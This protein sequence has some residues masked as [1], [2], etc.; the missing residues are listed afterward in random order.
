MTPCAS[1]TRPLAHVLWRKRRLENGHRARALGS[2]ELH[3][4]SSHGSGGHHH[5]ALGFGF[6]GSSRSKRGCHAIVPTI[7]MDMGGELRGS[8]G[9]SVT[10][11]EA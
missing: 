8:W 6:Q 7:F 5:A 10:S 11:T 1:Q 2:F 4:E 9:A 3:S